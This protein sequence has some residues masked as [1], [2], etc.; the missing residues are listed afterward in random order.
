MNQQQFQQAA[1]L[2]AGLAARWFPH[3]NA[4]MREYGI[5]APVDQAMFIAQVGHESTG[6]TRLVESFNYSIAGLNGFVRAG[7]LTQDQANM[8]GRRTYEKV[9]PLERQRAIANLV[10]SKRL[11]NNASGDGWKYRGRG[12]IHITGLENYRDCGAALKLDLVSTPELLSEDVTAARSAAWFY[13]SKGCLKYPGDLLRVTQI[14]NGGQNGL[15][16][17]QAR[18]AAARRVL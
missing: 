15:E 17:R 1:G 10:Y 16:D 14:I 12:L 18:Y 5:T 8:L 13:T 6:F 11:G 2:S 7:R 3:I 4:A 9:L